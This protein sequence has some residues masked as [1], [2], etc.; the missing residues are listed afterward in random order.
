MKNSL[1]LFF[2]FLV[3]LNCYAQSQTGILGNFR[4]TNKMMV[5]QNSKREQNVNGADEV[6]ISLKGNSGVTTYTTGKRDYVSFSGTKKGP[7]S[8]GYIYT[9]NKSEVF[10]LMQMNIDNISSGQRKSMILTH[11]EPLANTKDISN[12]YL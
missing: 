2:A 12:W 1:I 9:F 7:A 10:E 8:T 6:T 3:H 11:M 4:Y 5:D